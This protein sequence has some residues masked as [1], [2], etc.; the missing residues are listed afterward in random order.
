MTLAYSLWLKRVLMVDALTLSGLY[1]MRLIA[2]GTAFA[3]TLSFWLL[4]FS[5]FLF[6]SLALVKRYSELLVVR[7]KNDQSIK[8]RSYQLSD[9]EGLAQF[10]AT[11]GYMAVLVLAFYIN[12]EEVSALYT[13]PKLIWMLCPLLLF[14]ISRIWLL[15]R[16]NQ[17]HD[18]PVVF[19]IEDQSSHW[20]GLIGLLIIWIAI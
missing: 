20:C 12:S 13:H 16:R 15:A 2:G 7:P 18:D 4:A 9:L 10:G 14:W 5:M 11:S 6:L 17:M 1:T 3:V 19:A 8:G